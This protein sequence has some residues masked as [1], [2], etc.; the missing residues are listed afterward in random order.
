MKLFSL[1]LTTL[2]SKLYA[3]VFA[4]FVARVVAFF[5]LPNSVS[6]L[7][8]DEGT[9]SIAAEWTALGK[10]A[11]E[12]PAYGAGLY[13]AGKSFLLPAA[14]FNKVGLSP[15]DSVRIAASLYSLLLISFIVMITLKSIENLDRFKEFA[16]RQPRII[17]GL[18]VIFT[19]APGR[20]LWSILGLR[21]STVEFWTI[22]VFGLLFLIFHLQKKVSILTICGVIFSIVMLFGARPQVGWGVGG[23]ALL[24][25]FFKLRERIARILMPVIVG[26][27]FIGYVGTIPSQP[28]EF[29]A[30]AISSGSTTEVLPTVQMD[31]N[32]LCKEGVGWVY[33]NGLEFKCAVKK[34]SVTNPGIL[35]SEPVNLADRI[36]SKHEVNKLGAASFIKTIACPN[37]GNTKF[38]NYFC[39]LYRA[40]YSVFTFLFRPIISVDTTSQKS[41]YGAVENIFWLSAFLFIVIMSIRNGRLAFFSQLTPPLLF[42]T[43]YSIFAS[44]YEGNMGTAFRH[45]SL[46][47]WVVLLLIASTIVAT[48]QRKAEQQGISGSSQE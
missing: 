14:F 15:L 42:A 8:P 12:F 30:I 4:S 2:K 47:L 33:S 39:L 10:S 16:E 35:L 11:S 25:V 38:D 45:K 29:V 32:E 37:G 19:F 40:P 20:F 22:C 5:T 31:A 6:S 3:I 24:Y 48:Q 41:L 36:S 43:I 23:T 26:G 21:E 1:R 9:Y 46:I 17:L 7:G 34:S 44:A 28:Q 27:M 18:F 13:E